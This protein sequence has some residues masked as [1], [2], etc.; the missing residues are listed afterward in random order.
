MLSEWPTWA[1]GLW[2]WTLAPFFEFDFM[3]R[4]LAAAGLLSLSAG[5]LG[6]LLS[7]RRMSLLGDALGHAVLPGAA[8]A[9]WL[10]GPS[11]PALAVGAVGAGLSVAMLAGWISRISPLREDASLAALYLLALALGVAMVSRPGLRI[12]VLALLFGSVLGVDAA[13]LGY[14]AAL[15]ALTLGLLVWG[16][17]GWVLECFDPQ[18]MQAHG[19]HAWVWQQGFLVL[20]VLNLVAG[21]QSLGTLM[22]VGLMM[23]PAVSARLWADRLG[24][25]MALAAALGCVASVLGLLLSYHADLPSGPAIVG[26]AGGVYLLSLILAPAGQLGQARAARHRLG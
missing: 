20:V 2:Q 3:A 10:V 12:D 21:F 22:A 15:S 5:P 8:L 6:V 26:V 18:F 11:L 7:L 25:Q 23:L 19:R 17:R 13:T 1:T 14:T 24:V 4:A 9:L 16:W